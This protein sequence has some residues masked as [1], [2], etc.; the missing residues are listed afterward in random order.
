MI[1]LNRLSR[2]YGLCWGRAKADMAVRRRTLRS[3]QAF[4]RTGLGSLFLRL[5]LEHLARDGDL[6][7]ACRGTDLPVVPGENEWG[8][9]P[10]PRP[11]KE[12]MDGGGIPRQ[13][14]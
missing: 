14:D 6:C 3:H 7:R 13:L 2:V 10:R 5:E 12:C 9:I 8:C 11:S 1:A 4:V